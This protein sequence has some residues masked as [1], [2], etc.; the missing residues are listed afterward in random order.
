ML[1]YYYY[2]YYYYCQLLS[3]PN[4]FKCLYFRVHPPCIMQLECIVKL[5]IELLEI[6]KSVK[7]YWLKF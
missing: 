6:S 2:Y 3:V 5:D 7:I 1:Y 4:I